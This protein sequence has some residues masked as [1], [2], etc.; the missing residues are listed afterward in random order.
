MVQGIGRGRA[1]PIS[2]EHAITTTGYRPLQRYVAIEHL[3]QHAGATRV[4]EELAAVP[5]EATGRHAKFQTDPAMTV[6]RPAYHFTPARPEF[7]RHHA[8]MLLRAVN[9]HHLNRFMQHAG[10]L[11]GHDLRARHLQFVAFTAHHLNKD[12]QLQFAPS[13]DA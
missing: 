8:E 3:M 12:S 10:H 9:N 4:G 13:A 2:D 6:W 1:E 11:F 5:D 7:L